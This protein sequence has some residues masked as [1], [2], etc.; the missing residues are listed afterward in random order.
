MKPATFLAL[1]AALA[2]FAAEAQAGHGHCGCGNCNRVRKVCKLVPD[3]KKTTTYE[4]CLVCEDFCLHGPSKCVGCKQVC[5]CAGKHCEKVMQPTCCKVK[6]KAKLMKIPVV[7]E[8]HG[9]KCVVVCTCRA[10][11][12]CCADAREATP[13]EMQLAVSEAQRRGILQVAHEEPILVEIE[14]DE[15]AAG[16]APAVPRATTMTAA[17]EQSV[18]PVAPAP[19]IGNAFQQLFHP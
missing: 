4:Y 9:W 8:E 16:Q 7:K 14:Q 18:A 5:D 12:H 17:F 13:A 15:I 19:S 11:G 10:C 3:V 2:T 6:T 1:V